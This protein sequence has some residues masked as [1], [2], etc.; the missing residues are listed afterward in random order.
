MRIISIF[1]V[2]FILSFNCLARGGAEFHAG[3]GMNAG[4][5]NRV[6]NLNHDYRNNHYGDGYWGVEN[7]GTVLDSP[8]PGYYSTTCNNVQV[9]DQTGDCW[10]QQSCN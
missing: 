5:V 10:M 9:C 3:E 2:T 7:T 6:N 4:A 1:L 8:T